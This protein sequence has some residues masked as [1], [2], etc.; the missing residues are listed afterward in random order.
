LTDS[1]Q[2]I[3]DNHEE[4]LFLQGAGPILVLGIPVLIGKRCKV[5]LSEDNRN[6]LLLLHLNLSLCNLILSDCSLLVMIFLI[7]LALILLARVLLHLPGKLFQ[8]LNFV[9]HFYCDFEL[10]E[11]LRNHRIL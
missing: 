7:R 3:N 5:L 10:D 9:F 8:I 11:S 6:E 1:S 4:V 2:N